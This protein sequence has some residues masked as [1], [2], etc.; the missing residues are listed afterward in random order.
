MSS[1]RLLY[2]LP[3]STAFYHLL[4]VARSPAHQVLSHPFIFVFLF[5]WTIFPNDLFMVL[6]F[7]G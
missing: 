6:G 7:V 3:S 2:I 1:F 5:A 4:L